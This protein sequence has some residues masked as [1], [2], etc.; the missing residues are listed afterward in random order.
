MMS[1]VPKYG[2]LPTQYVHFHSVAR[3]CSNLHC[4]ELKKK[5]RMIVLAQAPNLVKGLTGIAKG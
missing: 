4:K 5:A 1:V 3:Y 2:G